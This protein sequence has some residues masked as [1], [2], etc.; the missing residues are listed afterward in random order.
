MRFTKQKQVIILDIIK[1][2]LLK[3]KTFVNYT[4]KHLI[5]D[6]IFLS[7]QYNQTH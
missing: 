3:S 4:K 5:K 1:K 2:L 6:F 7:L